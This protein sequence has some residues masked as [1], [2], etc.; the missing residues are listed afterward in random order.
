MIA[1]LPMTL[2]KAVARSITSS[3]VS[4]A[5]TISTRFMTGTGEKKCSPSMRSGRV[6]HDASCAMG[7]EDVLDARRA[8]GPTAS[9]S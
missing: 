1:V 4:S 7:M 5:T 2:T 9:S 6:V 3:A 8:S